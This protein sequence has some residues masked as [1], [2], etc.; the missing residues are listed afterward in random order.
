MS[1]NRQHAIYGLYL[2]DQPDAILYA[3]S[4]RVATLDERLRQHRH[5]AC[6]TTA[7]MAARGGVETNDLRMRVLTYWMS[8][9]DPNPENEV[10]LGLQAQG[11]CRW[12]HPYAFSREDNQRGGRTGGPIGGRKMNETWGKTPKAHEARVRGGH[13]GN[14]EGKARG[15]RNVSR[16]DH[17]RAGRIGARN[18]S[19]EAKAHGGRIGGPIGARKTNDT[20]GTTPEAHEARVRGGRISM[21]RMSDEDRIRGGHLGTCAHW[22]SE[23]PKIDRLCA[24]CAR[25]T[26]LAKDRQPE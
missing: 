10:T 20:W 19:P 24:E 1:R 14:H 13:I 4:W 18:Q 15:G 5:G 26:I 8:G 2:P 17:I 23:R 22:H 3:G 25:R 12:N 11:A 9:V 21:S 6:R 7:K 16:E